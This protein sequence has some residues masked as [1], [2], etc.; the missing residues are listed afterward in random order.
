MRNT[1]VL[2]CV[3]LNIFGRQDDY[4]IT[5]L[6]IDVKIEEYKSFNFSELGLGET[7]KLSIADANILISQGKY[8]SAIDRIHTA[9]HGYLRI[10][11]DEFE[12][13]VY[14]ESDSMPKLFN[15]LYRKW[16]EI[17]NSEINSMMLEIDILWH[18]Q[19]KRLFLKRRL[20][21]YWV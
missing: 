11:L 7:L 21:L 4:Y 13:I 17:S 20:N 8:S 18:I 3:K 5:D 10:C 2:Y 16:E 15:L 6:N 12:D 9:M 14:D 1:I 19:I